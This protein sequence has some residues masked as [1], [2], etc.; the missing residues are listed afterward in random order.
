M[1]GE[2]ILEDSTLLA[3]CCR[4]EGLGKRTFGPFPFV[5]SLDGLKDT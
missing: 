3:D 2:D 4:M 1:V 5:A